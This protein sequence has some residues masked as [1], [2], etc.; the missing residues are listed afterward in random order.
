MLFLG[1]AYLTLQLRLDDFNVSTMLLLKLFQILLVPVVLSM[2]EQ[3]SSCLFKV[4][5]FLLEV[6]DLLMHRGEWFRLESRV[7]GV[8]CKAR[9][10]GRG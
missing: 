7:L 3:V 6:L 2:Q 9:L 4:E 5:F 10:G 1:D 8:C